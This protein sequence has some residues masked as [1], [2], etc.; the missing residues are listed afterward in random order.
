[1]GS[2]QKGLCQWQIFGKVYRV[3]A[4]GCKKVA[5]KFEWI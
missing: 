3:M 4:E 5:V 1:M 2:L